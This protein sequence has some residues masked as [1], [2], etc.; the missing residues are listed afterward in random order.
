[1]GSTPLIINQYIHSLTVFTERNR[2]FYSSIHSGIQHQAFVVQFYE[3][4]HG[5]SQAVVSVEELDVILPSVSQFCLRPIGRRLTAPD[6]LL[7]LWKWKHRCACAVVPCRDGR[8][9]RVE[10]WNACRSVA[11]RREGFRVGEQGCGC[12]AQNEGGTMGLVGS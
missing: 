6:L 11:T 4:I 1:V 7:G 9:R 5:S 12:V 2:T 10:A 8:W 3:S